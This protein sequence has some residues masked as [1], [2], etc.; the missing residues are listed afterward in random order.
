MDRAGNNFSWVSQFSLPWGGGGVSFVSPIL[1]R[2]AWSGPFPPSGVL[3]CDQKWVVSGVHLCGV[4]V[5]QTC[6]LCEFCVYV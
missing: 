6:L 1:A 3:A 2:V 4:C 5:N